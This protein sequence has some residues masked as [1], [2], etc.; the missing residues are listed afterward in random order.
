M[1]IVCLTLSNDVQ[2]SFEFHGTTLNQRAVPEAVCHLSWTA[3]SEQKQWTTSFNEDNL[4]L[5]AQLT[6]EHIVDNPTTAD[7]Q[8]VSALYQKVVDA[9]NKSKGSA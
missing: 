4:E 8:A 7:V 2:Y 1:S 6:T 3:D 9:I 5:Q